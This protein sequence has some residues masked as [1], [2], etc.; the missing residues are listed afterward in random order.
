MVGTVVKAN[1]SDL[2]EET[3]EDFLR[4]LR[5][6][7]TGMVQEVVSK[8]RYLVSFYYGLEKYMLSKQLTIMFV[9]IEVQKAIKVREEEMIP[10]V[11]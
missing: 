4:R 8:R 6:N 9:R 7:M 11:N 1:V 2:E 5:I 10:E 3:R